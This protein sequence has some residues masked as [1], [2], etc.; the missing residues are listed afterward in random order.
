MALNDL[1]GKEMLQGM[2]NLNTAQLE[3]IK[4]RA[5][6]ILDRLAY[7]KT[8]QEW[9]RQYDEQVSRAEREKA[10]ALKYPVKNPRLK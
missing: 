3:A 5:D 4:A 9:Q 2:K 10:E 6:E 7:G 8:K 1:M